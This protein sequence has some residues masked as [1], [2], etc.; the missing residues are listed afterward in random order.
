[1]KD[2]GDKLII[3]L[4]DK[5]ALAQYLGRK[6]PAEKCKF[7]ITASLDEITDKQAVF[8]MDKVKVEH[9]EKDTDVEE[10]N[11]EAEASEVDETEPVLEWA[12]S[13]MASAEGQPQGY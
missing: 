5:E 13:N 3:N 11:E 7:V 4:E 8:S 1:M 12:K 2:M 9:A 6:E 10:A